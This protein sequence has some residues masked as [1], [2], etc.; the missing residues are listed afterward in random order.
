MLWHNIHLTTQAHLNTLLVEHFSII[1]KT[2]SFQKWDGYGTSSSCNYFQE[3]KGTLLVVVLN[4]FSQH[5]E[6]TVFKIFWYNFQ[7]TCKV[8][9]GRYITVPKFVYFY[10]LVKQ[11]QK[12]SHLLFSKKFHF[13]LKIP[14]AEKINTR[15]ILVII[16]LFDVKVFFFFFS[17]QKWS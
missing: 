11:H 1:E 3:E 17:I 2:I 7:E 16:P 4:Q 12:S 6:Y 8:V 10:H 13:M 15:K 14:L 9:T 5:C